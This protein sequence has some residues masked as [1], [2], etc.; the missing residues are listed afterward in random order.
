MTY[1]QEILDLL[2]KAIKGDKDAFDRLINT[3]KCPELAAFCNAVKGDKNAEMWLKARVGRDWWLLVNAIDDD[4]SA[5]KE[6]QHRENKFE[7]SFVLACQGRNEGK[8]WLEKNGYS[9]LLPIC[10]AIEDLGSN[11]K[12]LLRAIYK[13]DTRFYGSR[14]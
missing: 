8:Y 10:A 9:N 13:P 12:G 4:E 11:R 7:V 5:L 3:E 1:S 2:L 14:N 6:L